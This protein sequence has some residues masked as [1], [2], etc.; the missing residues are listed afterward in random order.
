MG[1][2]TRQKEIEKAKSVEHEV[3]KPDLAN[4]KALTTGML[5]GLV[6]GE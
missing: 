4:E 1:I 5:Q 6:D 3:S 2:K